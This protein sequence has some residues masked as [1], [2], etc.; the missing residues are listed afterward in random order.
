M[1]L[2]L[3]KSPKNQLHISESGL[4]QVPLDFA[5]NDGFAPLDLC[6]RKQ[7]AEVGDVLVKAGAKMVKDQ[8]FHGSNG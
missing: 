3:N 1:A 8:K 4:P 6:V 7:Q 2:S 5:N